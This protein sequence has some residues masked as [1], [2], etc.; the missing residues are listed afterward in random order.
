MGNAVEAAEK[1]LFEGRVKIAISDFYFIVPKDGNYILAQKLFDKTAGREYLTTYAVY[2][3]I[4]S[5]YNDFIHRSISVLIYKKQINGTEDLDREVKRLCK[6]C[7]AAT[8]NL[9]KEIAQ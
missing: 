2:Q 5:L 7:K 8:E 4:V 9:N 3:N 1:C 6:L